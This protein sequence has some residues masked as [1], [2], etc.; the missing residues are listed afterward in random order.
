MPLTRK[1]AS[2]GISSPAS[3]NPGNQRVSS[4]TADLYSYTELLSYPELN[5]QEIALRD[6]LQ[7]CLTALTP[8]AR[9]KQLQWQAHGE[10]IRLRVDRSKFE[11][12][13]THLLRNALVFSNSPVQITVR[14]EQTGGQTQ[15][16]IQDNGPGIP[17]EFQERVFGLFQRLG[18]HNEGS[19]NGVGLTLARKVTELHGGTLTMRSAPGQGTVMTLT[20][21]SSSAEQGARG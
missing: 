7:G 17:A 14:A 4:L 19:G 2:A 20:L 5:L 10:D 6:L 9:Q 15:V 1:P 16:S 11:L 12:A 21:P 3:T 13:L 8:L 18:P